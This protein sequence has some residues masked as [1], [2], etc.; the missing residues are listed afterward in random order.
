M[1][2]GHNSSWNSGKGTSV[3]TPA[4]EHFLKGEQR[5]M[6]SLCTEPRG[7]AACVGPT[8][9]RLWGLRSLRLCTGPMGMLTAGTHE[10]PA[11]DLCTPCAHP[12][13]TSLLGEKV[14]AC[15]LA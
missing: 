15:S 11:H 14:L 10:V 5:C 1:A 2:I 12:L 13:V 3:G 6:G 8:R 7:A 4:W 9:D